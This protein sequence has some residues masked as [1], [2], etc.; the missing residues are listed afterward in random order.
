MIDIF[1]WILNSRILVLIILIIIVSFHTIQHIRRDRKLIK[2]IDAMK[3]PT[4]VSVTD[5]KYIPLV[6]II[7]PAWKEG[8]IFKG[9]LEAL[10]NLKYPSVRVIVNAGGN[11][12]TIEIA[13]SFKKYK[14]F[15]ILN[16][17]AGEGKLRAINDCLDYVTEG[18]VHLIDADVYL[19]DESIIRMILPIV[20]QKEVL[21]VSA[22]KPHKSIINKAIVKFIYINRNNRFRKRLSRYSSRVVGP[23]TA[24]K[25]D[26]INKIGKFTE[27]R[28]HDDGRSIFMDINALGF[29][30]Y[31]IINYET[32][33][34]NFPFKVKDYL[35]QN[36]RW[37]ENNLHFS[38]QTK[39]W[40][41][42]LKL[43]F[44][45][46]YSLYIIIFPIFLLFNLNLFYIGLLVLLSLYLKKL[47]KIIFYIISTE[48]EKRMKLG[49]IFYVEIIFYSYVE[50]FMNIYV[51]I[52]FV[53]F[54]KRYKMRKN[55]E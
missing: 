27:K 23:N 26:I 33:S 47:R 5:L 16:Q 46:V 22:L 19:N 18:V 49:F 52:E 24:I 17:K 43:F 44:L 29:K 55:I 51:L 21:V 9:C 30:I 41:R 20:N 35:H 25:Y 45:V 6:N 48:K 1:L 13:N 8:K 28:K 34:F 3:E 14:N 11:D 40:I 31:H 2:N 37:I 32:A 42:F 50:V 39:N 54:R 4:N 12:E 36:V 10:N 7:I 15:T 53:F 38:M